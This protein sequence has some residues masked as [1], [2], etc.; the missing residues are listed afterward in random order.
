ML[1][2]KILSLKKKCTHT[3]FPMIWGESAQKNSTAQG[4]ESLL[5]MQKFTNISFLPPDAT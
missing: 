3:D 5:L 1:S 2:I 4:R